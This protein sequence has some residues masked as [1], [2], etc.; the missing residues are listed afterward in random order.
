M[1]KTVEI[2]KELFRR[3]TLAGL[4]QHPENVNQR[5]SMLSEN[6]RRLACLTKDS[7]RL[8]RF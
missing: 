1:Q 5:D 7:F 2:C 8:L 3:E 6:L 4:E